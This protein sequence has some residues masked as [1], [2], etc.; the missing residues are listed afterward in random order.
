MR[1]IFISFS[2]KQTEEAEHICKVLETNGISCFISTRD[3]IAGEE[4][5][6]QLLQRIND[7]DAVVLLLSKDSNE[8]PHVLREVEY[9]VS[10]NTPIL[11]YSLEEVEL[12][13]SMK[14]F[15]MTHQWITENDDKETKLVDSARYIIEKKATDTKTNITVNNNITSSDVTISAGQNS[16]KSNSNK[17]LIAISAAAF[18]IIVMLAA[19]LIIQSKTK[20]DATPS[21]AEEDTEK[22][23]EKNTEDTTKD[24][25]KENMEEDS[26]KCEYSLGDTIT[27]GQ[28]YDEP[29]EW[30]VIKIDEADKTMILLSKDILSM[31]TFDAAEGGEYNY[32]DGVDY[33]TYDNHIIEDNNI[34]IMARGNNDWTISNL[35]TWLNSDSELVRY[36]DQAPTKKVVG[37]NYYDTEPGFLYGFTAEELDSLVP[38]KHDGQKDLV[39]LLSSDELK[40]L[41]KAGMSIYAAPTV[42]CMEHDKEVSYYNNFVDS[43]HVDSYYWWL[44]DSSSDKPNEANIVVTEVESDLIYT[45]ASVGASNYGVRPAICISWE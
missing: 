42:A 27:L 41:N 35:R 8:S 36:A 5:A 13:N 25:P 43:Y 17:L 23:I 12:S 16:E 3:L 30:R 19:A 14:Y 33:W 2:S 22:S 7:A 26:S 31:K 29:I 39:F 37:N 15:L 38:V 1:N 28:Y 21:V 18:I 40:W 20:L 24:S 9:A 11:V 10:H 32:Y 4:Y 44:R 6:A 45:P 34:S